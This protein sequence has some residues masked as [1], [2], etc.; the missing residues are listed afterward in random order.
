M[1]LWHLNII[2]DWDEVFDANFVGEWRKKA[3][4][5]KE[6]HVFFHPT[7]AKIWIDTYMPFRKMSPIFVVGRSKYGNQVLMPLVFWRRNWRNAFVKTI[8]PVGYSDFDYHDPI[9]MN[10][11][12]AQERAS[13]WQELISLLKTF[14]PDEI[15]IDGIVRTPGNIDMTCGEVCPYLSLRNLKNGDDL[16]GFLKTSLRGDIRRQIRRM[17][18]QGELRLKIYDSWDEAESTFN[19]FMA[20]HSVKW[21]NAYKAPGFHVNLL[22]EG[23]PGGLVEFSSLNVGNRPVAWHLGFKHNG[24]YY[25]YMPCGDPEFASYSPVK[26]HL[27]KLIEHV[28]AANY[29]V[30]DHLR[31]DENYKSGWSDGFKH[32]NNIH[33]EMSAIASRFKTGLSRFAHKLR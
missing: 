4:N 21:P 27:F 8:I 17:S 9:F 30:F 33:M 25:Y 22:R 32:V 11:P 28:I 23:L 10:D 15:I 31:G 24:I 2:S 19:K 5:W 12:T 29:N 20:E 14:S 7:I 16:L 1:E 6:T 18:E 13:F 3:D 26:V